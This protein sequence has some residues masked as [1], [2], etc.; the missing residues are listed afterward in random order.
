MIAP[1]NALHVSSVEA[2][3]QKPGLLQNPVALQ[4]STTFM[5]VPRSTAG[6]RTRKITHPVSAAVAVAVAVEGTQLSASNMLNVKVSETRMCTVTYELMARFTAPMFCTKTCCTRSD[7]SAS[8]ITRHGGCQPGS[9]INQVYTLHA[10][11]TTAR[12]GTWRPFEW[13]KL[14]CYRADTGLCD[15]LATQF[16]RLPVWHGSFFRTASRPSPRW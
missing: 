13:I 1:G 7:P 16:F 9:V 14:C 2:F 15:Q 11:L 10:Q 6:V 5:I 3:G 4:M 12:Q 8:L